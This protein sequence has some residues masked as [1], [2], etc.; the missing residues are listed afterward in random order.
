MSHLGRPKGA[1]EAK[2]SL[3][4]VARKLE[5]LL[6]K[7]V[8]FL[9]DCVGT[10]VE[11]QCAAAADGSVILLENLRF[12]KEEEGKGDAATMDVAG[13][14]SSLTKLGDV[15]VNDA[16]G[17]AHRAHSSMVG[18]DLDTRC[19]G[20]LLKKELAYFSK[21]LETPER[22]LLAILGGAKVADKIKL[23]YNM[24][25][26]VDSMI[27]AGGMAF[28]FLKVLNG[29]D[30]GDSLFDEEGAKLVPDIMEKAKA[31]G[32]TIHLP[33]D[34]ICCEPCSGFATARMWWPSPAAE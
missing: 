8:T 13:F 14:R 23:I 20:F 19:S 33:T 27:I 9:T 26:K 4:P 2:Y 17:T 24:L 6:G 21:A 31:R 1:P 18:V 30:I 11:S 32:V 12:H 16:F 3:A 29:K 15:Y 7:P 28:T 10:E 34:V 22:P 5:E 25:E